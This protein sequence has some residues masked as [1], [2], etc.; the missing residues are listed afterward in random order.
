MK[1]NELFRNEK[2]R[3]KEPFYHSL[4]EHFLKICFYHF[5][6]QH[7]IVGGGQGDDT[8]LYSVFNSTT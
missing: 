2:E 8:F 1:E 4:F 6:S 3:T 7:K 5:Q